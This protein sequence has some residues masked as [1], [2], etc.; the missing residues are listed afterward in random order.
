MNKDDIEDL[1]IY[2]K[3]NE[4]VDIAGEEFVGKL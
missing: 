1:K 4:L 2:L 3:R